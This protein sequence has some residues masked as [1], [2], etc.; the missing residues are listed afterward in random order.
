M[1]DKKSRPVLISFCSGD[2]LHTDFCYA[3]SQLCLYEMDRGTPIGVNNIKTTL[4]E[5]GRG[6]QVDAALKS[7][8]SHILFLDSDMVYPKYTL[9]ALLRR[10]KDIVGCTYSQR[11]SPRGFTHE[12]MTGDFDF[13]TDPREDPFEVKSLGLGCMLVNTNVFRKIGP[14]PW[15][16]VEFPGT[17]NPDGSDGHRS[18]DRTFCD[19]ARAAGFKVWCDLTLSREVK[20][21]GCFQFGLE[22]AEVMTNVGL[23]DGPFRQ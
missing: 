22:H 18:E 7:N 1:S 8:C 11:R 10:N 9:Q 17:V 2:M 3:L 16:R 5:V 13:P 19:K 21:I 4:I 23:A 15:F 6:L 14:R 12:S 20:H